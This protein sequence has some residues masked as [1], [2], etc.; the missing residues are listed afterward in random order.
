[1]NEIK[2]KNKRL[3]R[4]LLDNKAIFGYMVFW[5]YNLT[6]LAFIGLGFGPVVLPS[7]IQGVQVG[8]IPGFYAAYGAIL[9]A[10]PLIAV[11][12]G[13]TVFRRDVGKLFLLGYG[14]QGPLMLILAVRF[15]ALGQTTLPIK[16]IMTVAIIGLITLLWH[17]L[18]PFPFDH[19]GSVGY[20]KAVGLACL[21]AIGF[22]ASIWILFY[23]IPLTSFLIEGLV[24]I[25]K[26]IPE[27]FDFILRD[28]RYALQQ[29]IQFLFLGVFGGLIFLFSAILFALLPLIVPWLYVKTWWEGNQGIGRLPA[30]GVLAA[31]FALIGL[32]LLSVDRQPQ[33][34]A[35]ALLESDPTTP[36]EARAIL[37]RSDEIRA[38]LLNSYLARTRYL[39]AQNELDHIRWM[40]EDA[41]DISAT[42]SLNVQKRYEIVAR[43]FLYHPIEPIEPAA[44]QR[45]RWNQG[46]SLN[47]EPELAADL[48]EKFF[49]EPINEGEKEEVVRA[50]RTTWDPTRA[51]AAWQAVDDREVLLKEQHLAHTDLGNGIHGFELHEVYSNQTTIR[52]EVVYYF[53]LPETAVITGVWLG[54]G[55]QGKVFDYR[56]APRGAAQQVYQEQV[57][58]NVDPALVEQIGPQQ[59]RLR[60]FPIDPL[61]QRW[62]DG[63]TITPTIEDGEEMH[64]WL[65]WQ[66]LEQDGV[67]PMPNL[68]VLRNVYWTDRSVRTLPA[69]LAAD[70]DSWL[71]AS[72]PSPNPQM[73]SHIV[74]FPDGRTVFA[75]AKSTAPSLPSGLNFAIVLDRSFSMGELNGE[76][77]ETLNR[78]EGL[79]PTADVY[80]TASEFRGEPPSVKKLSEITADDLVFFGGQNSAEIMQQFAELNTGATYDAIIV[81]TD[82][83][84]FSTTANETETVAVPDAPVWMLHLGGVLPNGYDD[85]TLEIVQASGGGAANA[86]DEIL[87]RLAVSLSGEDSDII[88]GLRW[89]VYPLGANVDLPADVVTHAPDSPFA[90]IAARQLILAEMRANKGSITDVALLDGLHEIAVDQAIV[91]PFSSMIVLVND[92]QQRRLDKLEKGDD[93][94]EREVEEVGET[95]PG[96]TVTGVPEPEEWLL[97]ILSTGMLIWFLWKKRRSTTFAPLNI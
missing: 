97:I 95:A 85:N 60:V 84:T 47:S 76:I 18:D 72:M 53:S 71:P 49:D 23:A 16:I 75:D 52:Q 70:A 65:S 38:G 94:F 4:K 44:N 31:V 62:E 58:R 19:Q 24:E 2:P 55:E 45:M 63:D 22:Y 10:I 92:F 3:W 89:T 40:Y 50:V 5:I 78:L 33:A 56:V 12:L 17:M 86:L 73:P 90:K 81:L 43:P 26:D 8:M 15:F 74:I 51:Q 42:N 68:S 21:L 83:G 80:L 88:N 41:F 13:L 30:F 11:I 6:F 46:S 35:F 32:S 54:D 20:T 66:V 93:R 59:Y 48:Y 7:V 14:V 37:D 61:Q 34:E 57:R 96:P 87:T 77:E 79:S 91:T 28:L 25:I 36:A 67:I 64:M 27:F 1:M 39:S 9:I 69:G 82:D 29:G